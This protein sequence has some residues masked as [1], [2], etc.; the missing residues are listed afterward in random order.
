[1]VAFIRSIL[2]RVA[3]GSSLRARLARATVWMVAGSGLNQVFAMLASI[4]TARIL[5]RVAFGEFGAVRSTVMTMAVLAGGGLGLATTRYVAALR[6]QDPQR[7]GRLIR[8]VLSMAWAMTLIAAGACMLLARPIA[9]HVMKSENLTVPLMVSALAIVFSTVAGVQ[10]GV[11]AGCEAFRPV[12]LTLTI[13]GFSAGALMVTGAWFGGVTGA[14]LGYV[15][16]TFIAFLLRHR[17][18][19]LACEQA[20]IPIVPLHMSDVRSEVP[21]I[22]H[23]VLPSMLLVIGAQPAEWLARMLLVRSP[24]GMAALGLFTAAYSWAQLVQFVPSQITSP[25]LTLLANLVGAGDWPA[26]RRL[27]IESAGLVF[28]TAAAI[29]IPLALLSR[30]M[31]G[32]YGPSFRDGA[33]VFSVIVLAYAFGA[34]QPMLRATFLAAAREWLQ[35]AFTLAWGIALPVVFLLQGRRTAMALALSYGTAFLV[36]VV[37]QLLTA[38]FL[39]RGSRRAAAVHEGV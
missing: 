27:L 16:G 31:M 38:W 12:A 3:S 5:G 19:K 20:G 35:L 26:F 1:M 14:V 4:G 34:V 9:A 36:V 30:F 25:A 13:E 10:I 2:S 33:A 8:L 29:A 18:V 39:F 7:A 15:I 11:M 28:G 32:L 24:D 37:A 17:Q 21:F 22:V 23:A 6:Q